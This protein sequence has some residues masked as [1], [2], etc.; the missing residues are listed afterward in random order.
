[1]SAPEAGPDPLA[2]IEGVNS[3]ADTL[4]ALKTSLEGK[5]W[6]TPA[7][8]QAA[9]AVFGPGLAMASIANGR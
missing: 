9:L 1:M 6:S 8:E 3:V 5:G 4:D 2:F 7:A